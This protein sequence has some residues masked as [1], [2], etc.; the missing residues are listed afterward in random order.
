MSYQ[1]NNAPLGN[2]AGSLRP[3]TL[4]VRIVLGLILAFFALV[5]LRL[6]QVQVVDYQK[7]RGI[8]QKQY[9]AKVDLPAARGT[10]T[11]RHG[12]MVASN[13]ALVSYVAGAELA[14][15]DAG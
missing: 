10:L 3:V 5:G 14:A 2:T 15:E 11:D 1:E 9:Q 12:A 6:A 13:T 7:C 8:A 4:R